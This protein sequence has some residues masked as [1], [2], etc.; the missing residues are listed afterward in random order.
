MVSDAARQSVPS[1]DVSTF[2]V[3]GK[4][5]LMLSLTFTVVRVFCL[6]LDYTRRNSLGRAPRFVVSESAHSAVADD[7][8]QSVFVAPML[9]ASQPERCPGSRGFLHGRSRVW[10]FDCGPR[11]SLTKEIHLVVYES[12]L[13]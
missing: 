5:G 6:W 8:L 4:T 3:E 12:T 11:L 9:L 2:V 13:W 7:D 1:R 10:R